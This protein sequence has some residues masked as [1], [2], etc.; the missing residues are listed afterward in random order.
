MKLLYAPWR[1]SYS[2]SI[3][4]KSQPD[5][6]NNSCVFCTQVQEDRD[7]HHYIIKRYEH[8]FVTMNRYP[9]NAGHIMVL[10]VLHEAQ[11]LDMSQEARY[12]FI[13]IVARS[14]HV[15]KNNL[16]ADAINTGLNLGKDAGGSIA[17]HLHMHII[18]RWQGDTNFLPLTAETKVI[19]F[20]MNEIYHLLKQGFKQ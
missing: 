17:S 13:D 11:L 9:Y 4:R 14:I 15:V 6:T 1:S 16:K 10:P 3:D 19:S 8:V 20:D 5:P 7:E 18:P 12:E 2:S